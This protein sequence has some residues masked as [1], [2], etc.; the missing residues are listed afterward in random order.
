MAIDH[1]IGNFTL[2]E[3]K[4]EHVQKFFF[5]VHVYVHGLDFGKPEF[6]LFERNLVGVQALYVVRQ[7]HHHYVLGFYAFSHQIGLYVYIFDYIN[8]G[9]VIMHSF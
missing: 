2:V 1:E 8:I 7:A 5:I 9:C 6:S 3:K 4:R